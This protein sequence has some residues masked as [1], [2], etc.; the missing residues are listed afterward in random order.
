MQSLVINHC[1]YHKLCVCVCDKSGGDRLRSAQVGVEVGV[2]VGE[3]ATVAAVLT[4]TLLRDCVVYELCTP[5][6][7]ANNIFMLSLS[8]FRWPHAQLMPNDCSLSNHSEPFVCVRR[9]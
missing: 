9:D 6:C 4:E 8:L 5:A 1:L 3:V 7:Q 2:E